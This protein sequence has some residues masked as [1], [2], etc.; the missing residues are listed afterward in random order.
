MLFL[1]IKHTVSWL[2]FK[3]EKVVKWYI[4]CGEKKVMDS[5]CC[6]NKMQ[7]F[8]LTKKFPRIRQTSKGK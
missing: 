3:V 4:K 6:G 5:L 8:Y 7:N 2:S 1:I